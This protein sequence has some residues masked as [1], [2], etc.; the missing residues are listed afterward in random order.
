MIPL[1]RDAPSLE[2]QALGAIEKPKG[3]ASCHSERSEESKNFDKHRDEILRPAFGE[4]QNDT[5]STRPLAWSAKKRRIMLTGLARVWIDNGEFARI[6]K[7][8]KS[9]GKRLR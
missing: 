7:G 8:N 3:R 5:F 2:C 9:Y 4:A 1:K 6:N